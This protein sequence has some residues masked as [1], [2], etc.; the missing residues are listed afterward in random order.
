M[1]ENTCKRHGKQ[2]ATNKVRECNFTTQERLF[3]FSCCRTLKNFERCSLRLFL[4]SQCIFMQTKST[5]SLM[6]DISAGMVVFLVALPLCLGIALAS[7]APLFSGIVAGVI[8]GIIVSLI[9]GS[10]LSVSGPAA[11]LVVIVANGIIQSGSFAFFAS[12]VFLCGVFQ[13][14]F[15]I[16]R[17]GAIGEFVPSSVIRG[18]LS[19]IGILIII[20]QVPHAVGWDT[21]SVAHLDPQVGETFIRSMLASTSTMSATAIFI[22]ITSILIILL[23]E[24]KISKL[25]AFLKLVPAPLMAV[26]WSVGVNSFILKN[27]YPEEFLSN[28]G[29]HLVSLPVSESFGQF[30]SFFSLPDFSAFQHFST[31]SLGLTIALVAS[32]ETL[33]SVEATDKLDPQKRIANTNKELIAQGVG[34]CFCGLLGGLPM[35]AVIVRSSANVFAGAQTRKSAFVHGVLLLGTAALI[36]TLLNQ[37]PLASLAAILLVLGYKLSKPG[38]FIE[39]YKKGWTQFLPFII[40]CVAIIFTDLLIGV[41]IGLGIGIFFVIKKNTHEAVSVV[42]EGKNYF[43]R[44]NKD[45]SFLHRAQLKDTLRDLPDDSEVVIDGVQALHVD[46]DVIDV[47]DD[48]RSHAESCGMK[49]EFRNLAVMNEV[50]GARIGH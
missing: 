42:S 16:F 35:T 19:A 8:G 34:N 22:S 4:R 24:Q 17:G 6:K 2:N 47:L 45:L 3:L 15:G 12:A 43:V 46:A 30:V 39:M 23:W 14:L 26:L 20:K 11:G 21:P 38:L 18:M 28:I 10:E 27:F 36:P 44:F 32:I 5:S 33:L 41:L 25:H 31:Y 29:S 50:R 40:T 49:V 7:G 37:I 48:C 9:S 13:I 1:R